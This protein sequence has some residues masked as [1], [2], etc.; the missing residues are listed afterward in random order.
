MA[1][2]VVAEWHNA[3]SLVATLGIAGML[4]D[5][6]ILRLTETLTMPSDQYVNWRRTS[7]KVGEG[8]PRIAMGDI[9][10]EDVSGN[11]VQFPIRLISDTKVG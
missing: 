8:G 4:M 2:E 6:P 11:R 5:D 3:Q 10:L 1:A 7:I 9:Y